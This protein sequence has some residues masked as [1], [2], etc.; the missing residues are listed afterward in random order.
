MK[1]EYVL[2]ATGSDRDLLYYVVSQMQPAK[3]L[4]NAYSIAKRFPTAYAAR[5]MIYTM[6]SQYRGLKNFRAIKVI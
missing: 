6:Q 4:R 1:T 3:M 2:T 5:G